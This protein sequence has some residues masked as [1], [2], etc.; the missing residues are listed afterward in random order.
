MKQID[1]M[2]YLSNVIDEALRLSILTSWT[3]RIPL[4]EELVV[5]GHA[6]PAGTPII[7]A[8]GV[9]FQDEKFWPN[10]HK[11][12]PKRFNDENKK[13]LPPLAFVPFG[14]AGKRSCY[15]AQYARY[16]TS[17]FLSGI[18]RAFE[19]TLVDSTSTVILV[20]GVVTIPKDEIFV[21]FNRRTN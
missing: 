12:N 15:A 17:L 7:Q 4:D 11:F 20:Y 21:R 10:P 16:E 19:V 13:K 1:K 6:I 18:I 5:C 3:V 2:S 8:F 9:V 14:F